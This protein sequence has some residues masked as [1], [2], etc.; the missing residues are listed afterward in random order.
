MYEILW[1][2][3]SG[4]QVRTMMIQL[5]KL[6]AD[7]HPWKQE[8][9]VIIQLSATRV[10]SQTWTSSFKRATCQGQSPG[11][12]ILFRPWTPP[13]VLKAWIPHSRTIFFFKFIPLVPWNRYRKY[14]EM[15]QNKISYRVVHSVH[16][17]HF[18][19]DRKPLQSWFL[20]PKDFPFERKILLPHHLS[21]FPPIPLPCKNIC[22]FLLICKNRISVVNQLLQVWKMVWG[23]I[24][25]L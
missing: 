14:L 5:G 2:T 9:V 1:F 16:T 19:W 10:A 12:A 8:A 22:F 21:L 20:M 6:N 15:K 25:L 3:I 4:Q 23:N 17:W 11:S 18:Y 24:I 7:S 13:L